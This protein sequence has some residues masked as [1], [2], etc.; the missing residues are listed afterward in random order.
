MVGFGILIEMPSVGCF[1]LKTKLSLIAFG[2]KK[3]NYKQEQNAAK[4][5]NLRDICNSA[6]VFEL[7]SYHNFQTVKHTNVYTSIHTHPFGQ[8]Q[9]VRLTS[10]HSP[11]WSR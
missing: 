2:R 5:H 3:K 8:M 1:V 11:D 9:A 4:K 6:N 10:I 7:F